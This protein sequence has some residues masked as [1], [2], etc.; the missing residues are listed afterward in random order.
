MWTLGVVKLC[1][2]AYKNSLSPLSDLPSLIV[3]PKTNS[4]LLAADNPIYTGL[5]IAGLLLWKILLAFT[6]A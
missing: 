4:L 1:H 5:L 2:E 3:S 6:S